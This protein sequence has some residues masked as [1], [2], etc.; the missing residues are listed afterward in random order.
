MIS[1]Y[2]IEGR[3]L[4]LSAEDIVVENDSTIDNQESSHDKQSNMP[5]RLVSY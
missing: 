5:A 4:H 2:Y 1:I 3:E